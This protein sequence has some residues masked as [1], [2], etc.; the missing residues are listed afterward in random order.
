[1]P[2]RAALGCLTRVAR[3]LE[4]GRVTVSVRHRGKRHAGVTAA[5]VRRRAQRMLRALSLADAELSVVLCDDVVMRDLNRR[6]RNR[7]RTTDVLA[8]AMNEGPHM[9]AVVA[10]PLGDVV[11][12]VPTAA[13]QARTAGKRTVDEITILLAHGL[14]HL[15]GF[16]H[17]TPAEDRRMRARTDALVGAALGA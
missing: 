1:M 10:A 15:L 12:S 3:R 11:I 8:F 4:A 17:V 2:A 9:P 7:D 16:D 13:R 5:T 6:Y 14:L